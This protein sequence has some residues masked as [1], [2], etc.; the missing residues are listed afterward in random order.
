MEAKKDAAGREDRQL[1]LLGEVLSNLLKCDGLHFE[2]TFPRTPPAELQACEAYHSL[3]QLLLQI[4]ARANTLANASDRAQAA[5]IQHQRS[6][7]S[8]QRSRGRVRGP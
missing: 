3:Q 2:S 7:I 8:R 1:V 4:E 6:N 5:A